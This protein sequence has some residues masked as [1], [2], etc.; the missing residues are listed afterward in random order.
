MLIPLI[1]CVCS[2]NREISSP[3]CPFPAGVPYSVLVH[4]AKLFC[5]C[6]IS[7]DV[8]GLSDFKYVF[9][10]CAFCAAVEGH[11]IFAVLFFKLYMKF[12]PKGYWNSVGQEEELLLH[13]FHVTVSQ[14]CICLFNFS[15]SGSG[16][17]KNMG[18]TL[19]RICKK[20]KIFWANTKSRQ[21]CIRLLEEGSGITTSR[22]CHHSHTATTQQR[23]SCKKSIFFLFLLLQN[24][25]PC[26][27]SHLQDF[28][29]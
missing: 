28:Q 26:F 2:R 6:V 18:K 20:P 16:W 8:R 4:S 19:L 9:L 24:I 23:P 1:V 5:R 27:P 14:F 10:C 12:L 25:L 22:L 29:Q 7:G 15:S 17:K 13:P 21:S 11:A 3:G